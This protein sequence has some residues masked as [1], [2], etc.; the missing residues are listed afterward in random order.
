MLG[1]ERL[2]AE[3]AG[4]SADAAYMADLEGEV[5]E[6][7]TALAGAVVTEIAAFRGQLFGRDLG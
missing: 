4:L 7:R 1:E 3:E 2:A 5:R 6:Y